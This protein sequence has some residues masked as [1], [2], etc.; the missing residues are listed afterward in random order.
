MIGWGDFG[1]V[2]VGGRCG[3]GF[4]CGEF[5]VWWDFKRRWEE[6]GGYEFGI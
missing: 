2:G 3:G 4:G 5:G 6:V 1:G